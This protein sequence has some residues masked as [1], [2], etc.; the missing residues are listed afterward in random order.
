N[1]NYEI[2]FLLSRGEKICP[3]EVKSSGYKT[4]VSLDAFCQK[5]SSRIK[6]KYLFYTK[7]LRKDGDILCLPVYMAGLI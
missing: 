1:H 2:D 5:F 7:D 4:H 3:V 6:E